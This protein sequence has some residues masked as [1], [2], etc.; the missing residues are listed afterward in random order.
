MKNFQHKNLIYESF[1]TQKFPDLRYCPNQQGA[2]WE[3]H[4]NYTVYLPDTNTNNMIATCTLHDVSAMSSN[5]WATTHVHEHN[6][7]TK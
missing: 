6:K 5:S 3:G 4:Y 2:Y 1:A 7:E